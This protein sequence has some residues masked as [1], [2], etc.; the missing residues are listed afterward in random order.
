MTEVV[1]RPDLK[2]AGGEVNDI[3]WNNRFIGTMTLVY[4][5]TD[6]ISGAIQLEQTTLPPN[7][8]QRVTSELQLYVQSLIDAMSIETCDVLVTYSEYDH[9][10]ATDTWDASYE[11]V[12]EDYDYDYDGSD[13][14]RLEDEK[15]AEYGEYR[16]IHLEGEPI[17]T[18]DVLLSEED[19]PFSGV[20]R[21]NRHELVIVA[22][23]RNT[24]EY[25]IY[26]EMMELLAEAELYIEDR[27]VSGTVTWLLEPDEEELEEVADLLV[28]DFDKD[29]ID[30]FVIHM[31][32]DHEIIETI[33][34]THGDLLDE[35]DAL[36]FEEDEGQPFIRDD[37]TVVL[38]RD[39]GEMLTYE[40][41]QSSYGGL[42]IGTATV[43]ISERQ[44]TGFIDF[45][46]PGN[47]DDREYIAT[48]LMEELDK[49]KEY[50]SFNVTML[51]RNQPFEEL[52]FESDTIH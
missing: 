24:V 15:P 7:A 20:G 35:D 41:Y 34:L 51:F 37:Y 32:W 25:H 30:A 5:E 16:M 18:D 14:D 48:L 3:L 2:T 27:E 44:I 4:R 19:A 9:I 43:D 31:E 47:S 49:E 6:R 40:I 45:R 1:I 23:T 21:A 8:K 29:E 52:F 46:E 50:E 39:D 28:S 36:L 22:E 42:P 17:E 26:D 38:A 33:E 10:I 11:D 13:S 12:E